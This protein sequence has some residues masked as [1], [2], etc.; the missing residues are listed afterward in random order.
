M[1]RVVIIKNCGNHF[2]GSMTLKD[3]DGRYVYANKRWLDF[4]GLKI[5][6][7][8]G[9]TDLD[10]FGDEMG[11][12]IMELDNKVWHDRIP[13]EYVSD[14]TKDGAE[15]QA[16]SFKWVINVADSSGA[17]LCTVT[18]ENHKKDN[19]TTFVNRIKELIGIGQSMSFTLQSFR[20]QKILFDYLSEGIFVV[21]GNNTVTFINKACEKM[22]GY[23]AG[24]AL[25]KNF[26]MFIPEC[27]RNVH[28]KHRDLYMANP[29]PRPMGI[30]MD[31][32]A[33]RKNGEEF[34][35][36]IS[37]SPFKDDHGQFVIVF[38][39]DITVRRKQE[40]ELKKAYNDLEKHS[41]E[42]AMM[43]DEI[44]DFA[45]VASHHLQEPMRKMQ[46]YG[47]LLK[48]SLREKMS[49]KEKEDLDKMLEF[50]SAARERIND[51]LLF[52]KLN[53]EDR[54]KTPV[55][56]NVTVQGIID[57]LTDLVEKEHA[58]IT[59]ASE[60]PTVMGDPSLL[61]QLFYNLISNAL[62][63]S[64]DEESPQ[65]VISAKKVKSEADPK[66]EL[67]EIEIQDNG[68]GFDEKYADKLFHMFQ[69]IRPNTSGSGIGLAISRKICKLHGGNLTAK[70]K[71]GA[72]ATFMATL[73]M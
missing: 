54:I 19:V 53:I 72:G 51:F 71:E 41:I 40:D 55:N 33:V 60:L 4:A 61:K 3:R 32:R 23:E 15:L 1:N 26:E 13:L 8:V 59:I 25:G 35:V 34:P 43:N 18:D 73:A 5:K 30:G 16:Y 67:L 47:N 2:D 46:L 28:I 49:L 69:K 50:A 63:F 39:T 36:E 65:I 64:K 62:K 24:E 17:L 56:L 10:V 7:V 57:Q 12:A 11:A 48:K 14:L 31:L 70:G 45:Y 66:T 27:F 38:I 37:L 6:D 21:G 52:T 9:K 58:K 44:R 42:L 20:R 22:F 68:V 29:E